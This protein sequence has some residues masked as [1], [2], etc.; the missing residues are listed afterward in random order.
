[1]IK[2]RISNA[3]F[4]KSVT[5]VC[6]N[7][8]SAE[9]DAAEIRFYVRIIFERQHRRPRFLIDAGLMLDASPLKHPTRLRRTIPI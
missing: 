9:H 1:M 6:S 5:I 8:L 3:P 2:A 7:N 4:F